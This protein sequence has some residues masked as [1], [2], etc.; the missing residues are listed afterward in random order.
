MNIPFSINTYTFRLCCA[1]NFIEGK[2]YVVFENTMVLN[3][4]NGLILE[5]NVVLYTME[6]VMLH[7]FCSEEK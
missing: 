6:F 7:Y 1:I 3:T 2:N 4:L 5:E